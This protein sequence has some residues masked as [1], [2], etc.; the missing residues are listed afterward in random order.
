MLLKDPAHWL[1]TGPAFQVRSMVMGRPIYT[2][3]SEALDGKAKEQYE[4]MTVARP[5]SSFLV[6]D[7]THQLI[8]DYVDR[9]GKSLLPT[10]Y[11]DS[12]RHDTGF[13]IGW[14]P[15]EYIA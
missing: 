13:T 12:I 1:I 11:L 5:H 8:V 3:W 7:V 15:S 2:A 4:E 6:V 10:A 14:D 9:D